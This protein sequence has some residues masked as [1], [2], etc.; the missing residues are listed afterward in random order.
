M[1][2]I[3]EVTLVKLQA[4]SS[5]HSSQVLSGILKVLVDMH[6]KEMQEHERNMYEDD[7]KKVMNQALLSLVNKSK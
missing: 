5:M 4:E 6:C 7:L 1:E 3:R 2:T